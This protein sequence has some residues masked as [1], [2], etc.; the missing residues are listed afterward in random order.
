MQ[1]AELALAPGQHLVQ[2]PLVRMQRLDLHTHR[3][4][5]Q[6]SKQ[7]GLRYL[8]PETRSGRCFRPSSPTMRGALASSQLATVQAHPYRN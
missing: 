7:F 3:R 8:S 1:L 2:P 4:P 6:G 5:S